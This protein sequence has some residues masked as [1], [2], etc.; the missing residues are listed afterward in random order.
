MII[1]HPHGMMFRMRECTMALVNETAASITY[2][3]KTAP[4][5]GLDLT[6]TEVYPLMLKKL[7]RH[8]EAGPGPAESSK[9]LPHDSV[10]V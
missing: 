6:Q 8:S 10:E 1:A 3:S 4:Y 2:C 7:S 5:S 9:I